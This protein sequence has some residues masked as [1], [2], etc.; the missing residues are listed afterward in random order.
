M[1]TPV[2]TRGRTATPSVQYVGTYQTGLQP[3][4]ASQL[5][6]GNPEYREANTTTPVNSLATDDQEAS[7]RHRFLPTVE[8]ASPSSTA[9]MHFSGTTVITDAPPVLPTRA[10]WGVDRENFRGI[11]QS[12]KDHL[13]IVYKEDLWTLTNLMTRQASKRV[14]GQVTQ[15]LEYM[16]SEL[17]FGSGTTSLKT[18]EMLRVR[19]YKFR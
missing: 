11:V 19:G 10:P 17:K 6:R 18:P 8:E 16:G 7:K 9:G 4:I 12:D 2:A 13:I 3:R 14:T 5:F 1:R 15:I